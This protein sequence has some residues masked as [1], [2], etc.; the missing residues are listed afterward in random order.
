MLAQTV[1][2]MHTAQNCW[3]AHMNGRSQGE[4]QPRRD[5]RGRWVK[6]FTGNRNGR[7]RKYSKLD[8]GDTLLFKD[9]ILEVPTQDGERVMT[10]EGAILHRLFQ[11]AL[12]GDVRAQ[13]YLDRKFEKAGEER[14]ALELQLDRLRAQMADNPEFEPTIWQLQV[15]KK[16]AEAVA[17]PGERRLRGEPPLAS[18]RKR[19]RKPAAD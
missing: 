18:R 6:G 15:M 17:A 9:H 11:S 2:N 5:A 12:K 3:R 1:A 13:I 8:V 7:P 19:R 14:A 10:R 4:E 16:V